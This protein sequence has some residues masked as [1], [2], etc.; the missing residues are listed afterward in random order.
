VVEPALDADTW[1]AVVGDRSPGLEPQDA[2]EPAIRHAASSLPVPCP[3]V[4]WID[5]TVLER[6]GP[7]VL[8]GTAGVWVAPG[9]PFRSLDGAL[10]GIRWA[11][12]RSIPLIGTCGGFQL[13]IVEFARNVLGVATAAHAEYDD[14]AGTGELFIDELLCSLVGQSMRVQVVDPELRGWY[15]TATP[16]ERYYCRFGLDP[17]WREPL[18]RAGLLVAGIDRAD[19]DVRIMRLVEHPFF[20]LTLFVPQT[21]SEPGAP[22]PLVTSFVRAVCA[23]TMASVHEGPA[24]RSSGE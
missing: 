16:I 20:L 2:I 11:R 14:P 6:A 8:D 17:R 1:I 15:G 24:V 19:G 13:A 7:A 21:S 3:A 5:T 18:E 4:R 22:H 10:S 23:R 12:E 9:G